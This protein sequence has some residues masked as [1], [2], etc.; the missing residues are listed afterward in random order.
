MVPHGGGPGHPQDRAVGLLAGQAEHLGAECREHHRHPALPWYGQADVGPDRRAGERGLAPFQQRQQHGKVLPHVP[1][2]LAEVVPVPVLDHDLVR[3]ADPEDQAA[4]AAGCGR[5][6]RLLREGGR[7]ARVGGDHGRP[8]LDPAHLVPDDG[9]RGQRVQPE[10]VAQPDRR[11]PVVGRPLHLLAQAAHRVG[12]GR[13]LQ[14]NT[15]AHLPASRARA[16][17]ALLC[18]WRPPAAERRPARGIKTATVMVVPGCGPVWRASR[19]PVA[20]QLAGMAWGAPWFYTQRG[21]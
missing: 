3:H 19:V 11:E 12:T 15:D 7:M 16:W 17:T 4:T 6:Q 2:R 14:W 13:F 21:I 5:G 9:E 18:P 20:A 8:Q 1:D 10:D